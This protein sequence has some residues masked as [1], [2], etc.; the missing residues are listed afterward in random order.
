LT[1]IYTSDNGYHLGAHRAVGGKALPFAEDT[2]LPFVV[3]GPGIPKGTKSN[4]PEAHLDLAPT[5]LDI[6]GLPK[7]QWPPFFDGRSLLHQWKHP[8]EV[9]GGI[10]SA[11]EILNVEFWG[12]CHFEAPPFESFDQNSYKTLRIVGEHESWLFSKWC[13]NDMELYN[14]IASSDDS[15]ARMHH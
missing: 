10:G 2:N 9:L 15:T 4:L 5:F 1:V 7:D 13:T 3:R 12:G 11:K 6:S 8:N 14:T